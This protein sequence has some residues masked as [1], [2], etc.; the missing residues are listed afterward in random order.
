MAGRLVF[1]PGKTLLKLYVHA[2]RKKLPYIGSAVDRAAGEA[3]IKREGNKSIFFL[4]RPA[5]AQKG[6]Y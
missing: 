1:R 2:R 3:T 6:G 5:T 4:P